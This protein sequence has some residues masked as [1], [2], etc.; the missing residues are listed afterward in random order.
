MVVERPFLFVDGGAAVTWA[1]FVNAEIDL[2]REFH[3]LRLSKLRPGWYMER[4][5][6]GGFFEFC[7]GSV[8]GLP[9]VEGRQWRRFV[10]Q[11]SAAG[12]TAIVAKCDGP[13]VLPNIQ[14]DSQV[15][16]FLPVQSVV[17]LTSFYGRGFYVGFQ[18]GFEDERFNGAQLWI[19][20]FR[21]EANIGGQ[22]SVDYVV[23]TSRRRVRFKKGGRLF[24]DFVGGMGT[25]DLDGRGWDGMNRQKLG[26]LFA[27][28]GIDIDDPL[29]FHGKFYEYEE[30]DFWDLPRWGRPQIVD[31]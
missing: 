28:E 7:D 8:S 21:R 4:L 18:R 25:V 24:P 29:L 13:R 19:F 16:A 14:S 6:S 9:E 20:D 31:T 17:Q 30:I 11:T 5:A 10:T 12:W 1:V 2:V 15:R 27:V 22:A 23:D 26:E 3:L